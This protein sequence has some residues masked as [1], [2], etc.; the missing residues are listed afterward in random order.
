MNI[1]MGNS[2]KKPTPA[3]AERHRLINDLLEIRFHFTIIMPLINAKITFRVYY[4]HVRPIPLANPDDLALVRIKGVV[5]L[6][7]AD[8]GGGVEP[9]VLH[10]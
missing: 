7:K 8:G 6:A 4:R 9:A 10:E 3:D 5:A 1:G 2:E